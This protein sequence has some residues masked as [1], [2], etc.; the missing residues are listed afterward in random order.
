[1]SM[2]FETG[3]WLSILADTYLCLPLDVDAFRNGIMAIDSCGYFS[4]FT[5]GC[6]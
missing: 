1:M 4:M 2:L 6:R 3:L 5:I